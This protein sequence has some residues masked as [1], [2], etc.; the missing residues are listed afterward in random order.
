MPLQ[1]LPMPPWMPLQALLPKL[2]AELHNRP[3]RLFALLQTLD[4]KLFA[5]SQARLPRLFA[6]FHTLSPM[7][8]AQFQALLP[9]SFARFHALLPKLFAVLQAAVPADFTVSHT[10]DAVS[11]TLSQTAAAPSSTVSHAWRP[12]SFAVSQAALPESLIP[13]QALSASLFAASIGFRSLQ[14][15]RCTECSLSGRMLATGRAN[16]FCGAG[17]DRGEDFPFVAG[18][19]ISSAGVETDRCKKSCMARFPRV[20]CRSSIS[21]TRAEPL[22]ARTALGVLRRVFR[23][24]AVDVDADIELAFAS[25]GCRL[26]RVAVRE[27]GFGCVGAARR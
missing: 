12:T 9:D 4:P 3:P 23:Y 2:F 19:R 26:S 25:G 10:D 24:S 15:R 5:Q 18:E 20:R 22:R 17:C 7:P 27:T 16:G 11:V 1:A 13:L 14:L 6:P 8:L 21:A